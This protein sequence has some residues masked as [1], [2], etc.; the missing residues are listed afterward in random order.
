MCNSFN[1]SVVRLLVAEE[2]RVAWIAAVFQFQCGAIVSSGGESTT[3]SSSEFQFQCGAIVS[4]EKEMLKKFVKI[5]FNSSVV[6]LLALLYIVLMQILFCFNSSVVR[7]LGFIDVV[8][9]ES[10][11]VSIPVWCDC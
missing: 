8:F 7:L 10:Y 3:S 2:Q 11:F 1:S 5:S 9:V 4:G 6:R